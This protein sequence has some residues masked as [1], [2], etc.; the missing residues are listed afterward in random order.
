MKNLSKIL[1]LLFVVSCL[2]VCFAA[3]E[4]VDPNPNPNP[5]DGNEPGEHVDYVAQL[6]LNENSETAKQKVTVKIYIDGDTTHFNVPA[7]V[8]PGGVLKARYLA[9]DTP[10]STGKIEPYGKTASNFT[11]EKLSKAVEILVESDGP[12]WEADSTGSRY[13]S[14]VWYKAEAGGA[15]RNL[16]L[17]ILQNGLAIASSTANNRYGEICVKA[18]NQAKAEKLNVHSGKPDPNMYYGE[19]KEITLKELRTNIAKY[20]G[21]KVAFEGVSTMNYNDGVY[22]EEL[23]EESG[24]YFG[25]YVYY[26]KSASG[27]VIENVKVGNRVRVVGTVSE[28]QGS[29]QVSGL[30]YRAMK[31]DDPNNTQKISD[32]H[33]GAF[34]ETSAA[35]LL[36]KYTLEVYD[37]E[38]KEEVSR[39]YNYGE[40]ALATS[41]TVKHLKV[42]S[43]Y[44]TESDTASNGAVSI[45]CTVDGKTIT[46]RTSVLRDADGNLV[47]EDYYKGKTLT[48]RGIVDEFNGKYQVAVYSL[49]D[50]TIED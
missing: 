10:E 4:H 19:A 26:G 37:H 49:S 41:V 31:P 5:N 6:T 30:T 44:T 1:L 9:I 18:L 21:V 43:T 25:M 36:G 47:E 12:T 28:F 16:N 15:W 8:I 46:V 27:N 24:L 48:V 33:S 7:S 3:C 45:T 2:M 50:I 22:I 29:Y 17:E 38:T 23:D 14:W 34:V 42:T 11:K 39:E 32:G 35:T 20:A 40:L 13:L